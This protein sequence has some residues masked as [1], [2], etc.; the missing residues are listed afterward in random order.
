M[1]ENGGPIFEGSANF[2]PP[3][4]NIVEKIKQKASEVHLSETAD[5]VRQ[6]VVDRLSQNTGVIVEK[7]WMD[8]YQ[9]TVDALDEGKRKNLAKKLRI[10]AVGVAKVGRLGSAVSDFMF[11]LRGVGGVL[12]G[13]GEIRRPESRIR[14]AH[15]VLNQY[16]GDPNNGPFIDS[17]VDVAIKESRMTPKEMKQKGVLDVGK[18]LLD[19]TLG[20]LRISR[21]ASGWMA[22]IAGM[23][24]EKVAQITNKILTGKPKA[25]MPAPQTAT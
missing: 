7:K 17:L 5:K 13:A 11:Q 25:E 16:G 6:R 15:N 24:G 8:A 1:S 4:K 2:T 9:K 18:G 20:R 10:V 12:G 14:Y 21:V 19:F 3:K 23:G 22:D